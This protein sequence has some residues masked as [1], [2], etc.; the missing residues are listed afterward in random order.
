MVP[1]E[2]ITGFHIFFPDPW[3]K[4]KHH[5]RR[6]VQDRFTELLCRKLRIGGYIYTVTDWEDYAEQ[7]LEVLSRS[8]HLKNPYLTQPY[9]GFAL[10]QRW[11]PRTKFEKKGLD[12]N[13]IIRELYFL[14]E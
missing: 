1:D 3:P 8:P 2:S 4:K 12:K 6:L 5:K 10:P 7:M 9:L 13:H 11:R 14:K